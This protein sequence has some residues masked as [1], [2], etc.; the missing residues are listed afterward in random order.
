MPSAAA[1]GTDA[2][3]L[4]LI[5]AGV[6]PGDE[7]ITSPFT[8]FASAGAIHRVGARPVLVDIDPVSFNIDPACVEKAITSRTAA[9]MPVHIFG[10][11][12]LKW[13]HSGDFPQPTTCPSSKTPH[14]P[15]APNIGADAP[16]Y[17]EPSP[18]S[19]SS[20]PRISAEPATVAS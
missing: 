4:A 5:A 2:L 15:S 20:P 18:A 7:V 10:Q 19:A 14:R 3:I 13:N 9:I 6:K 11:L 1:S 12:P 8:F 17:S 16:G